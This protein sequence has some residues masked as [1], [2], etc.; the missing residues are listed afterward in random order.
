[1]VEKAKYLI[2]QVSP[3][4][5]SNFLM[6]MRKNKNYINSDIEILLSKKGLLTPSFSKYIGEISETLY[7]FN[8]LDK[9]ENGYALSGFGLKMK[10]ILLKNR[11]FFFEIYHL[12][13]YYIFDLN[14]G[15]YNFLPYRSYQLL[16]DYVFD[17]EQIP[18]SKTIADY[19]DSKIKDI[20]NVQGSF[21]EACIT[22]GKVWIKE[23][24]PSMINEEN[25]KQLRKPN[26]MEILLLGIDFYYR[27][28]KIEYNDPLFI[29]S[30][31]KNKIS[32]SI[33]ISPNYFDDLL[34]EV[35]KKYSKYITVKYNV[36]GSYIILKSII[37][38]EDLY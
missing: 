1:M 35:A 4:M 10:N 9:K 8:M 24:E 20:Y 7:H 33:L 14:H 29:D 15:D 28:S 37:A 12:Y 13:L 27:V 32:K 22:R 3:D 34:D 30:E 25:D 11:K 18:N 38:I 19:I 5:I 23:L 36:A 16:C 21:S 6:V 31:T 17:S 2:S 26:Y